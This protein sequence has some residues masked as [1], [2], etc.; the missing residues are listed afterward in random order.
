MF[1]LMQ[2]Y[3]VFDPACSASSNILTRIELV[4]VLKAST[5]PISMK[6]SFELLSMKHLKFPLGLACS[7]S[8]IIIERLISNVSISLAS[9]ASSVNVISSDGDLATFVRVSAWGTSFSCWGARL[10]LKTLPFWGTRNEREAS[11]HWWW[12]TIHHNGII[13]GGN[14]G[15]H[16]LQAWKKV[17]GFS[18]PD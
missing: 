2:T 8:A 9:H 10:T 5:V 15:R 18:L 17:L 6:N 11:V 1:F 3:T 7:S 16:F 13:I 14:C 12:W 4:K